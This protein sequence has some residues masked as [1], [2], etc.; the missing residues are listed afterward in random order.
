VT[1]I[2]IPISTHPIK[3]PLRKVTVIVWQ[4]NVE[5]DATFTKYAPLK[6]N[7]AAEKHFFKFKGLRLFNTVISHD[8]ISLTDMVILS[9]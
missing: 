3:Q 2:L 7:K 1:G 9:L 5:P 4:R 6:A 8:I